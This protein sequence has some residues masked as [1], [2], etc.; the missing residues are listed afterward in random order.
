MKN[1]EVSN[2]HTA[3]NSK[4][5]AAIVLVGDTLNRHA[6]KYKST[7]DFV[8]ALVADSRL[9]EE[10]SPELN[11]ILHIEQKFSTGTHYILFAAADTGISTDPKNGGYLSAVILYDYFTSQGH[12]AKIVQLKDL[13]VEE[14]F[15]SALAGYTNKVL[16]VIATY[17]DVIF[18]ATASFKA[19]GFYATLIGSVFN[20]PVYYFHQNFFKEAT[21]I[22]AWPIGFGFERYRIYRDRLEALKAGTGNGADYK[23]LPED[24]KLLLASS[25]GA[26]F[27]DS[28]LGKMIKEAEEES[29]RTSFK[30]T[31]NELLT[32]FWARSVAPGSEVDID[33]INDRK[34]CEYFRKVMRMPQVNKLTFGKI[35]D[36]K[37]Q[38]PP[39]G[40]SIIIPLPY[41][42]KWQAVTVG[43]T[44]GFANTILDQVSAPPWETPDI[45][46]NQQPGTFVSPEEEVFEEVYKYK[47]ELKEKLENLTPEGTTA[48]LK[49][50]AIGIHEA[51]NKSLKVK[52]KTR[53][54]IK[55]AN[56][57]K[58]LSY[59]EAG[60]IEAEDAPAS[61]FNESATLIET[62][63]A[64]KKH[65]HSTFSLHFDSTENAPE[66]NPQI[67][68]HL[69][70]DFSS[71]AP[72][73]LPKPDKIF[74]EW[75]EEPS[76]LKGEPTRLLHL[77]ETT[78][79]DAIYCIPASL[80]GIEGGGVTL[81]TERQLR[82]D[83]IHR[84]NIIVDEL[85]MDLLVADNRAAMQKQA[86]RAAAS[87]IFTHA[88]AH[89]IG[90][91]ALAP[92]AENLKA[93]VG[94]SKERI[95]PTDLSNLCQYLQQ[96]SSLWAGLADMDKPATGGDI[97]KLSTLKED[98]DK[99]K[100]LFRKMLI[101]EL[102]GKEP[103]IVEILFKLE[104]SDKLEDSA[105]WFPYS[106]TAG[107]QALYTI[108]ETTVRNVKHWLMCAELKDPPAA[109]IAR[110]KTLIKTEGL[111]ITLNFRHTEKLN[112]LWTVEMTSNTELNGKAKATAE[113]ITSRYSAL[114]LTEDGVPVRKGST[115]TLI[116]TALLRGVG[117]D[118]LMNKE[119]ITPSLIEVTAPNEK[120]LIHKFYLFK[121]EPVKIVGPKD[122]I[123]T[124]A[125]LRAAGDSEYRTR[126]YV[127]NSQDALPASGKIR[128]WC[129]PSISGIDEIAAYKSWLKYWLK[130]TDVDA[131]NTSNDKYTLTVT[132]GRATRPYTFAH[133][134]KPPINETVLY[135]TSN[136]AI[137]GPL[138]E[139]QTVNLLGIAEA[140]ETPILIIDQRA[141]SKMNKNAKE[142][143]KLRLTSAS[144]ANMPELDTALEDPFRLAVIHSSLLESLCK[145]SET[146]E[147]Q[148][149]TAML[150]SAKD[151]KSIIYLTS[152]KSEPLW[153]KEVAA[154]NFARLKFVPWSDL[155]QHINILGH[156]I[157]KDKPTTCKM[158]TAKQQLMETLLN[159]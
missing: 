124:S 59:P 44:F 3:D 66:W 4:T 158:L 77:L 133:S 138:K 72:R 145:Q 99:F 114:K 109:E 118:S 50:V 149:L 129:D 5:D 78:K 35:S 27:E 84:A 130:I 89:D 156:K 26:G 92:I 46:T 122:K 47:S 137:F 18:I 7:Q 49:K 39:A 83:E 135:T 111:A 108:I 42:G 21:R 119:T 12:T 126:F 43:V 154:R 90:A 71:T 125:E 23:L 104:G 60:F 131:K 143:G 57:E 16:E 51:L 1:D 17:R 146:T 144:P 52:V 30:V 62:L 8:S 20:K 28:L 107:R 81:L 68:G 58:T 150:S 64:G 65:R 76:D 123:K 9:A 79:L 85:L 113:E 14:R 136:G 87:A 105:V 152:G 82:P 41:A 93:T 121:G 96:K 88:F 148:K 132:A 11:T 33:A 106:R 38:Q 153:L 19:L 127:S 97:V 73:Q 2:L 55:S 32:D 36:T 116:C 75:P 56:L 141:H 6:S 95:S 63:T 53:A 101:S 34:I 80:T 10:C 159:K 24:I 102:D 13:I 31:V 112:H 69:S 151:S 117:I 98:L 110:R 48:L 157:S 40:D 61:F 140:L 115:E 147:Q 37:P 15:S 45:T 128:L 86:N 139:T 155:E 67:T 103:Q 94:R 100:M 134:H 74:T 91:H 25:D 29:R 54:T 120:D 142:L 22:E 70:F